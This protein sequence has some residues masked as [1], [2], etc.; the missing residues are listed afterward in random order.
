MN[1]K[2]GEIN[3]I[4]I[5]DERFFNI[6]KNISKLGNWKNGKCQIGC[7][8]VDKHRIISSGFNQNKTSPIQMKY[9]KVRFKEDTPHTLHAEISALTPLINDQNID[10]SKLKIYTYREKADHSLG[11]SR[12]CKSCMT[13]IKELGIKNIYYTTEDGY[14]HEYV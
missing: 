11:K 8:V 6:A 10:F 9:N 7:I 1:N 14:C 13:L 12:P 2:I 3:L 4:S 5:K